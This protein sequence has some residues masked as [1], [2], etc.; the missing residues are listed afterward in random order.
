M[1]LRITA[2]HFH[3]P[4]ELQAHIR[5]R[6]QA[7][8]RFYDGITSAHVVLTKRNG[9]TDGRHAEVILNV[10]RQQ[11]TAEASAPTHQEAVD[12]CAE[13]LRRQLLKYKDKL[14]SVQQQAHR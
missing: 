9:P 4:E 5:E 3:A 2:R 1:Q 8:T 14:R 13:H 11:L 10:Y 7:L 6:I 12:R